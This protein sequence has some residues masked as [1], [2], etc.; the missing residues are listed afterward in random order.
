VLSAISD[1]KA[2]LNTTKQLMDQGDIQL[3]LHVIDILALAPD[4]N[5]VVRE[6]K[7]LKSELL[8]LRSGDVPSVVSKNLYL[9]HADALD[10]ELQK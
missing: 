4:D 3:A 7:R 6:A 1:R 5:S 2:V 10:K 8:H 9:S